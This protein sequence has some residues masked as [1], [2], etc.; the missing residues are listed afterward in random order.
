VPRKLAREISVHEV[1]TAPQLGWGDFDDGPL[2]NAMSGGFEA[3]VTVDKSLRHQQNL[4]IRPFGVIVLRA[5]TN[6]IA[7]LLPLVPELRAVL[8]EIRPGEVREIGITK[9][10][11]K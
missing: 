10:D 1:R 2:L 5:K 7:D 8:N 3:L 9:E 11:S 6:R 4:G